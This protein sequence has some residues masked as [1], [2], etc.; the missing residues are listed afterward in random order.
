MQAVTRASQVKRK[1]NAYLVGMLK[2]AA[3]IVAIVTVIP[4]MIWRA[5]RAS[6]VT[7]PDPAASSKALAVTMAGAAGMTFGGY[8]ANELAVFG[9]LAFGAFGVLLQAANFLVSTYY[10][11]QEYK[12]KKLETEARIA[13][14]GYYGD[15]QQ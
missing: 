12:L 6:D 10:K 13:A 2:K 9:G 4:F 8:S 15:G 3:A 14:Q 7:P 5:A 1:A 11:R